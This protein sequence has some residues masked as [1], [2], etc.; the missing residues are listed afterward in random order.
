MVFL[1]IIF[2]RFLLGLNVILLL[3]CFMEL[4]LIGMLEFGF[5]D[6][7]DYVKVCFLYFD[8]K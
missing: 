5:K 8:D 7:E 4:E 6:L 1:C 2:N 3:F